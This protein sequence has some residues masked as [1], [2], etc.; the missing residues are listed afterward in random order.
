MDNLTEVG[1]LMTEVKKM[2]VK[3]I[4][5]FCHFSTWRGMYGVIKY[6]SISLYIFLFRHLFLESMN[7]FSLTYTWKT[8]S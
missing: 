7:K 8:I 1:N 5:V 2:R 4:V 6:I 3:V